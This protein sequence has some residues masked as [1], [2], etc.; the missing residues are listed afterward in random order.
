MFF[1]EDFTYICLLDFYDIFREDSSV[2]GEAG[3][4]TMKPYETDRKSDAMTV[5]RA[6]ALNRKVQ[7][8]LKFIFRRFVGFSNF[9]FSRSSE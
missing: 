6:F 9:F 3:I 8:N 7:K 1:F 4:D 2:L 5:K